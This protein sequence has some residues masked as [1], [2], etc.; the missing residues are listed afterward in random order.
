MNN[1]CKYLKIR[2]KKKF[3]Y[4]YCSLQ[5]KIISAEICQECQSK[6]YKQYNSLKSHTY[7]QAKKEKNRFSI[8]G[9]PNDKCAVCPSKTNLTTHEIFGG[10]NRNNSIKYG[11]TIK[12]CLT[13]HRKYQEDKCFNDEWHKKGQLA[14]M[15][16]Y[17]DLNFIDIFHRN[18]L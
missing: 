13:C 15:K 3:I 16:S 18:Y 2:T 9:L 17:P 7:K 12:L 8:I 5:K 4:Y 1:K 11:L 6:E 14:F 10:S